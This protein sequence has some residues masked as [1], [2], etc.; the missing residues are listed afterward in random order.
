MSANDIGTFCQMNTL[1]Y[2]P[3]YLPV[4]SG[5]LE[6]RN[7]IIVLN[8]LPRLVTAHHQPGRQLSSLAQ[9]VFLQVASLLLPMR[10]YSLR[11][12]AWLGV[13]FLIAAGEVPPL[14]ITALSGN[15]VFF[16]HLLPYL[17]TVW[18]VSSTAIVYH[19]HPVLLG[20]V[21]SDGR[22]V[23]MFWCITLSG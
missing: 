15:P 13:L 10:A 12:F 17:G 7:L 20:L 11:L 19:L 3:S 1:E 23:S 21:Y 9:H 16:A 2:L 5:F 8:F 22:M 18:H 4:V 14:N 6:E